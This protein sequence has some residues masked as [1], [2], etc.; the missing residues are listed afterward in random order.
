[1]A[2]VTCSRAIGSFFGV[3]FCPVAPGTAG[4]LVALGIGAGLLHVGV[5][6]LIGGIFLA[7]IGGL[8][9]VRAEN[10]AGDA[11]WIVID[12]VAGQFLALLGLASVSPAGLAAAFCLF[13]LFDILKPGP[14]GW[15]DRRHD[16]WGVMGDDLVAGGLSAMVLLTVRAIWPGLLG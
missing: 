8:W 11:G 9:A 16:S 14:V 3:G 1:M 13:R 5:W 12:E 10:T 2:P 15:M 4:S 6:A 7:I